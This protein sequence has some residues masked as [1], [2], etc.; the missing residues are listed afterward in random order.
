MLWIVLGILIVIY[1][2]LRL[3]VMRAITHS[4]E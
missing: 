1:I 4:E 2:G 3:L